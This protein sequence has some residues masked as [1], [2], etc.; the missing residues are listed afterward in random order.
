M[1]NNTEYINTNILVMY[2]LQIPIRL[3][4]SEI[5]IFFIKKFY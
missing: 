4:K 2:K 5:Q 1:T 3:N